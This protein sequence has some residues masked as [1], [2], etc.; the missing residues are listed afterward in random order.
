MSAESCRAGD[1]DGGGAAEAHPLRAGLPAAPGLA[2][3]P[4]HAGRPGRA[5][6][7]EGSPRAERGKDC[8]VW[9][10]RGK[11]FD[12]LCKKTLL[13]ALQNVSD[14]CFVSVVQ[15]TYVLGCSFAARQK[16]GKTNLK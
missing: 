6:A 10:G 7:G 11:L 8:R 16:R 13:D 9:R 3:A 14:T 2:R 5:R 15:E 1:P 4:R 12:T